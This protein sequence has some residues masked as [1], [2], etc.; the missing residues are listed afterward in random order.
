M[1]TVVT[2]DDCTSIV[3]IVPVPTARKRLSVTRRTIFGGDP[4][5][6]VCIRSDMYFMPSMKIPTPPTTDIAIWRDNI[7]ASVTATL[8]VIWMG[9][10]AGAERDTP[11]SHPR[12]R[13]QFTNPVLTGPVGIR[14]QRGYRLRSTDRDRAEAVAERR[15]TGPRT[16]RRRHN[17]H[18]PA[19]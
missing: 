6:T 18:R 8:S 5:A 17:L 2:E 12:R 15:R 14:Y 13:S 4:P 7:Q 9:W 19:A 3:T 11:V 1:I 10:D 16:D